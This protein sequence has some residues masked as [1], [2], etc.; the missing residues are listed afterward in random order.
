MQSLY[1]TCSTSHTF[2]GPVS[3]LL[4]SFAFLVPSLLSLQ[5]VLAA[6]ARSF[7]HFPVEVVPMLSFIGL[8]VCHVFRL[9]PFSWPLVQLAL[10]IPSLP[11]LIHRESA[12][13][14]LTDT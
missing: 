6:A 14:G 10:Q 4:P 11:F 3:L 5:V 2:P 13:L 9:P 1:S 7:V 8:I 12:A